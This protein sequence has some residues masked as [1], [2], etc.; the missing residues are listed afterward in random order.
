MPGAAVAAAPLDFKELLRLLHSIQAEYLLIGGYAVN[1]YGYPRATADL[2]RWIAVDAENA[3][4]IA[5]VLKQFGLSEAEPEL[6]L[7]LGK[8]VRLGVPL[9]RIE[10]V[11]KIAGVSFAECYA[12]RLES[13][14]NGLPVKR[15]SLEHRKQNKMAAGRLKD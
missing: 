4:K 7:E 8:M 9:L 3:N 10:F 5:S 2:D 14:F 15:I 12:A 1:Y 6:F 13:E 11:T